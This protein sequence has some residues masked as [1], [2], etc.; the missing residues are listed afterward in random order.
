MRIFLA[1]IVVH[2]FVFSTISQVDSTMI[3][4]EKSLKLALN[5]LRASNDDNQK[6]ELHE[7]L[8]SVVR[9]V[10]SLPASFSYPFESLKTIGFIDS[11]DGKIRIINWN[12]EMSDMTQVYGCFIQHFDSKTKQLIVSELF[13]ETPRFTQRT[14]EFLDAFHW[15]GALYYK[16]IPIKRGSKTAYTLLAWDGNNSMSTIKIIDILTF[17]SNKPKF[18]GQIFKE[19]NTIKKRV[20]FE[21]AEK[22]SMNLNYEQQY[23]RITFDHLTPE[24]PTLEGFY[25]FYVPDFTYDAF[26]FQ[27]NKWVLVEDVIATNNRGPKKIVVYVKN[28]KTGKLEAK[29]MKNKWVNPEDSES[30]IAGMPHVAVTPEADPKNPVANKGGT[31]LPPTKVKNND[32]TGL[33]TTL[34]KRKVRRKRW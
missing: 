28:A 8:K 27:S 10:L 16:I 31:S 34:G 23:N 30:P 2:C 25:S 24:S 3:N 22:I 13:D 9:E 15:Y 20:Y 4:A 21:Y 32:P 19:K 17:S 12:V 7:Q 11:P 1:L 18:G 29:K 26:L 33:E 5:T 6:L 14:D